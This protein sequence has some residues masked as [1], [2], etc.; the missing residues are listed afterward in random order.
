MASKRI[1]LVD[2]DR[3]ITR[4]LRTAL[5][6]AG[7]E[8]VIID[9]P[10]G[11]EAVR[12]LMRGGVDLLVLDLK[13]P[14]MSGLGVIKRVKKSNTP[15]TPIIVVSGAG[16]TESE[17]EVKNLNIP[18]FTKPIRLEDF[19]KAAQ[20]AMGEPTEEEIVAQKAQQ[21][22]QREEAAPAVQA[23]PGVDER[24]S[25]LRRDLGAN[26]VLLVNLDAQ[27]ERRA[28]DVMRLNLDEALKHLMAAFKASLKL[29]K[30]LGGFVPTNVQFFDGDD[31]DVYAA[32][33]G[34]LFA[35]VIIF[36]GD[37]GAGQM[38][39]VMRYGRQCADDLL[40]SLVLLGVTD[41][42]TI[43][44]APSVVAPPAPPKPEPAPV[45][46]TPAPAKP[47]PAP[48]LA[49]AVFPDA[50]TP[51][52]PKTAPLTP[53]KPVAPPPPPPEPPKPE[54]PEKPLTEA[55]LKALDDAFKKVTN[56]DAGSFWDLAVEDDAAGQ[57][58]AGMTWEEF[59]KLANK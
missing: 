10:T 57:E 8:Y 6:T 15:N 47:E 26:A 16:D 25:A 7:K 33:V 30:L 22:Q 53:P 49:R 36:D 52:K 46:A 5:E 45:K 55:D 50:P 35:L 42:P 1:L 38:G 32:N 24:L 23:E 18:F 54:V 51:A 59:E 13:L 29:C 43:M 28:G 11:E 9:V 48:V 56:V 34:Q 31:W 39:P 40:N 58:K 44:T 12:E 2:D 14:G 20:R 19:V 3:N 17:T 27:V 4:L 41:E 37:R 21:Q